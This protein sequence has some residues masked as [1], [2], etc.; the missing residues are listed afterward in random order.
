MQPADEKPD[1]VVLDREPPSSPKD[2]AVFVCPELARHI[3]KTN[4]NPHCINKGS[5]INQVRPRIACVINSVVGRKMDTSY[6]CDVLYCAEAIH[7]KTILMNLWNLLKHGEKISLENNWSL[8]NSSIVLGCQKT[9]FHHYICSPWPF[10][11]LQEISCK[12]TSC[13]K[14]NA[15]IQSQKSIK[16]LIKS[17]GRNNWFTNEKWTNLF[18]FILAAKIKCLCLFVADAEPILPRLAA[19][20]AWF[21]CIRTSETACNASSWGHCPWPSGEE[22]AVWAL[23]AT[24]KSLLSLLWSS[25]WLLGAPTVHSLQS[26]QLSLTA[27]RKKDNPP[28]QLMSEWLDG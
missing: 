28:I 27:Q 3:F 2:W 8:V 26:P 20:R 13:R 18:G 17:N 5:I 4:T 21:P 23:P 14:S 1:I 24:V 22:Q 6:I 10:L 9:F 12:S 11:W 15:T 16:K 19:E 25:G 7:H